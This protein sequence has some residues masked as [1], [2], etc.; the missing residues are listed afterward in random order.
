MPSRG[1]CR[2]PFLGPPINPGARSAASL[3][4]SSRCA[5]VPS[6]PSTRRPTQ[7][8]HWHQSGH[9]MAN[10]AHDAPGQRMPGASR[11][12]TVL[13]PRDRGAAGLR[14]KKRI[15]QPTR[16]GDAVRLV[17]GKA[18]NFQI[19]C[20]YERSKSGTREARS[21]MKGRWPGSS[22]FTFVHKLPTS[23]TLPP[24]CRRNWAPKAR[25]LSTRG[26]CADVWDCRFDGQPALYLSQ[27][28]SL[29]HP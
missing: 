4:F 11:R 9:R 10:H 1:S 16:L 14:E 21:A 20:A 28:A 19:Y 15:A 27:S 12:A 8:R 24:S 22:T 7:A 29:V 3:A 6:L 18:A 25:A 26:R 2:C 23:Q 17:A 13:R 5:L